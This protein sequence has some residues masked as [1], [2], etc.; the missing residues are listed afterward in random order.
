MIPVPLV[1]GA[2]VLGIVVAA[3]AA[4]GGSGGSGEPPSSAGLD[5]LRAVMD[6]AGLPQD[7]QTFLAATAYGE[8][9][10]NNDVGLGP[11]DDPGR[12]PWLRPSKASEKLQDAEAKAAC[13]AYR[14]NE[15]RFAGS[16]Y[17]KARYC[18]GSGGFFGFL[19]VYGIV[20]GFKATPELIPEIDPWDVTDPIV[21]VVMAVGFAR[22]LM[23]WKRFREGGGTW[24]ALRVGWGNPS[25]M[26]G[27]RTN[28]RV[29]EKFG[30]HLQQLGVDPSFMDR[31]V[32]ALNVPKGGHLLDLL[33]AKE[34]AARDALPMLSMMEAA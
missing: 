8:S 23:K 24:L 11:N 10:W 32:P 27:A 31:K 25:A 2:V 22:G 9:K 12:P 21:S 26:G 17:P 15:D 28:D 1:A 13:N 29:R 7:W 19:P 16:P 18:F 5:E 20:S 6:A 3:G 30:K 33:E 14:K 4:G 34:A